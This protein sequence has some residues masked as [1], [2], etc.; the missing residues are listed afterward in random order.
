MTVKE[1]SIRNER[2]LEIPERLSSFDHLAISFLKRK[3]W[4]DCWWTK[5]YCHDNIDFRF[6]IGVIP[7]AP[8]SPEYQYISIQAP[9]LNLSANCPVGMLP[10]EWQSLSYEFEQVIELMLVYQ[11]HES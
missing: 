6:Q 1:W 10:T 3:S 7:S 2:N 11:V 9:Q 4:P 8:G 5:Y